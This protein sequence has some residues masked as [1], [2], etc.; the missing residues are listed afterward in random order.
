LLI[1]LSVMRS[2]HFFSFYKNKSSSNSSEERSS[3][4]CGSSKDSTWSYSYDIKLNRLHEE[5]SEQVLVECNNFKTLDEAQLG[6]RSEMQKNIQRSE[7]IRIDRQKV[8]SFGDTNNRSPERRKLKTDFSTTKQHSLNEE[9]S[10]ESSRLL[11]VQKIKARLAK[12]IPSLAEEVGENTTEQHATRSND[13][14]KVI[15]D[16]LEKF[17]VKTI[18]PTIYELS[19]MRK[20]FCMASFK[21]RNQIESL[22]WENSLLETELEDYDLKTIELD[23]KSNTLDPIYVRKRPLKDEDIKNETLLDLQHMSGITPIY[24]KTTGLWVDRDNIELTSNA[25]EEKQKKLNQNVDEDIFKEAEHNLWEQSYSK[26]S[27]S[28]AELS[29][30]ESV[31]LVYEAKMNFNR[32]CVKQQE[33]S[34]RERQRGFTDSFLWNRYHENYDDADLFYCSEDVLSN[35]AESSSSSVINFTLE[36][37][38]SELCIPLRSHSITN[39]ESIDIH[40][41]DT[42]ESESVYQLPWISIEQLE[43]RMSLRNF[44]S[45]FASECRIKLTDT[46]SDS[47]IK[48]VVFQQGHNKGKRRLKST[49]TLIKNN[50]N[51]PIEPKSTEQQN[52]LSKKEY[53]L[54]TNN[55]KTTPMM[56]MTPSEIISSSNSDDDVPRNYRQEFENLLDSLYQIASELREEQSHTH[57]DMSGQARNGQLL[58][59]HSNDQKE[60]RWDKRKIRPMVRSTWI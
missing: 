50:W 29:S 17:I 46:L 28:E 1:G 11:K 56:E 6:F 35:S 42:K 57:Y 30:P 45:S 20:E 12:I 52:T 21:Q 19:E 22:L 15:I 49:S 38:E 58:Q 24:A 60:E 47:K 5:S 18:A 23:K 33:K 3:I 43:N 4:P 25:L 40:D 36:K 13:L 7:P 53:W 34:I 41:T 51:F 10:L 16:H 32:D 55:E 31:K 54:G 37:Q 8:S 2:S 59:Q 39:N 44:D 48:D 27:S 9:D 26:E 14:Q